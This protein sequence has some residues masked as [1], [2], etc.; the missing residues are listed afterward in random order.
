[1]IY[2][3]LIDASLRY[4]NL[5]LI[6]IADDISLAGNDDAGTDHEKNTMESTENARKRKP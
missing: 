4:H 6:G 5:L 3:T 2:L 1:M